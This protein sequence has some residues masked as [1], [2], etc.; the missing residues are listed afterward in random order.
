MILWKLKIGSCHSFAQN[1]T[2]SPILLRMKANVLKEPTWSCYLFILISSY[3]S[4]GLCCS[5]HLSSSRFLKKECAL[6][7]GS[8]HWL[9]LLPGSVFLHIYT[10]YIIVAPFLLSLMSVPT[11]F[12][13]RTL[14][15]PP[16]LK[17]NCSAF[18]TIN[19]P[20]SLLIF[21][22]HV[23]S[24]TYNLLDYHAYC[25]SSISSTLYITPNWNVNSLRSWVLMDIFIFLL[26]LQV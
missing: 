22:S 18:L 4:R 2:I 20:Y 19:P 5:S 13:Q 24:S 21:P 26:F 15:W 6:S 17:Y 14:P 16:Y 3:S 12:S 7:L 1:L 10:I 8:F 25:F 9:F 11:P 23:S